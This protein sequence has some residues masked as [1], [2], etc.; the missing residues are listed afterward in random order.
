MSKISDKLRAAETT[1]FD[2]I[3]KDCDVIAAEVKKNGTVMNDITANSTYSD[4]YK[5]ELGEKYNKQASDSIIATAQ[6]ISAQFTSL[7]DIV[8]DLNTAN[9]ILDDGR[10]TPALYV[11]KGVKA[12]ETGKNAAEAII[13]QFIGDFASLA[14]L[15]TTA[16]D[17][18]ISKI[19]SEHFI[20]DI[21]FE[22]VHNDR[23]EGFINTIN[24]DARAARYQSIGVTLYS[25]IK[26]LTGLA[27]CFDIDLN[28]VVNKNADLTGYLAASQEYQMRLSMGLA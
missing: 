27:K 22:A 2:A 14:L 13:N 23:I 7:G 3:I 11:I 8:H 20:T 17:Q 25:F 5:K 19:I 4:E 9:D 10:L 18:N 21:D 16:G 15:A 1:I 24:N 6:D 26:Y 12:D 28:E